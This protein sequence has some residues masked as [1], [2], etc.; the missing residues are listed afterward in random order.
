[1]CDGWLTVGGIQSRQ[2][3]RDLRPR[4]IQKLVDSRGGRPELRFRR[5]TTISIS[6]S[7]PGCVNPDNAERIRRP[8]HVQQTGKCLSDMAEAEERKSQG[9]L[10]FTRSLA[11]IT[12]RPDPEIATVR[13]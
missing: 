3:Y 4:T 6:C 12:R 9:D 10:Q 13:E 8:L 7:M 2:L 5:Q 11:C 1:M